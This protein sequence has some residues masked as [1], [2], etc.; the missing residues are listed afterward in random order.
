MDRRKMLEL[1]SGVLVSRDEVN[2]DRMVL[3]PPGGKRLI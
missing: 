3:A 1:L 2:L